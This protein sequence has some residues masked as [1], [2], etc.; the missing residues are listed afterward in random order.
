MLNTQRVIL[1]V[2]AV[3][4]VAEHAFLPATGQLAE[5]VDAPVVKSDVSLI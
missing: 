1:L 4:A 2:R 5:R 3:L